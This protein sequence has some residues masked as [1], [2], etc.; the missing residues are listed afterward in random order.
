ELARELADRLARA[1]LQQLPGLAAELGEVGRLG[2]RPDVARDLAELLVRDVEPV[3]AA[4]AEEEVVP[5]DA[6]DGLRLE[7][8][9]LA[10]AVVLV[11]DEVAGAE[12]GER[13]DRAAEPRVGP[14]RPLAED[15]RVGQ[16]HEPELAP[17]EAAP[18][19]RDGE[20]ELRLA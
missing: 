15:L 10:D 13:L 7:S 3:V 17:D 8:E 4:E 12:I 14:R 9:Q 5:R 11:D 2:V 6:R 20:E 16:E 19:R 1:A 18:C